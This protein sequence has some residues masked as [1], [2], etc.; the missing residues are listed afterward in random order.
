MV[1]TVGNVIDIILAV[2][3]L[4]AVVRGWHIGLAMRIA[5]LA[6]F[7]VSGGIAYFLAHMTG[8]ISLY[9]VF[10]VIAIA[11]LGKAVKV[12]RIVDWI[13]VVGTVNKAGGAL[14]SFVIA[15]LVCYILFGFLF[16]MSPQEVWEQWGLTQEVID[17]TYLLRSFLND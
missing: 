17:G 4:L 14:V 10:F 9:G 6:V 11:V 16:Y 12:V 5:H 7:L 13:P 2:F 1:L 15:S 3:F 8:S